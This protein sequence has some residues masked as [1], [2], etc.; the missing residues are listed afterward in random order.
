M[1]R[2]PP[3]NRIAEH[4]TARVDARAP[5]LPFEPVLRRV[6]LSHSTQALD[7]CASSRE[8]SLARNYHS[9]ADDL[10]LGRLAAQ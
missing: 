4:Q 3:R 1:P 6:E 7:E 10:A 8:T 5:T 2:P 9:L